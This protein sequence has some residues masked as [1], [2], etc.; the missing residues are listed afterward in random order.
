MRLAATLLSLG[1]PALAM[2]APVQID[3]PAGPLEAEMLA[4]SDAA[5]AVVIVPGSGPIDRDGN[6]PQ[7]SVSSDTYK[8][9]AEDLAKAGIAS[10]RIDKRGFYGSRAA[11]ADPND[12][13]IAAYADDVRKWVL[14]ASE[15]APCVWI[16]GHSEGGLVALAAAR[17]A[18]ESLCGLILVATPGRPIGRLLVEQLRA[19]PGNAPLMPEIEAI[20]ADL[21]AG[22]RRDPSGIS[23]PLQPLF[24]E[25]VQAFM[26]DLF[27]YDPVKV[28]AAWKGPALI[29]QGT[30]DMQVKPLDADILAA[31]LPQAERLDLAGG[32]HMLRAD[33][34]GQ[35]FVTY[36]DP[37][38]P[39]H[40]DIVPGIV[41]FLKKHRPAN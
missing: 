14:R 33:V 40:P 2:A 8:L 41:R 12:V 9:L 23:A 11:I 16:A 35:P 5:N 21:E 13:S 20:V 24:A 6:S 25:S 3:G 27:S 32:T 4:V 31:A 26:I 38:L 28:A 34:P 7:A 19:I 39:L 29:V 15:L 10:L 36:A 18:P 37:S 1:L 22:R 30:A 17:Q